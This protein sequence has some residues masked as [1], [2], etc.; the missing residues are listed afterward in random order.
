MPG[1]LS[2]FEA[3]R[4]RFLVTNLGTE[5]IT[6][7]DK[8]A[9]RATATHTLNAP[10]QLEID[11]PSDHPEVN[12][13]AAA[14]DED[15][16]FID[17]GLNLIYWFLRW[18]AGFN[19]VDPPWV[20]EGAGIILNISDRGDSGNP[21]STLTA[22]DPWKLL[23]R[24]PVVNAAGQMPLAGSFLF[25]A[26]SRAS[27]IV[28]TLIQRAESFYD[29]DSRIDI[30][31]F[32]IEN[33]DPLP[34]TMEIQVG[35][36]VGEALDRLVE[37]G[38][39]D[40]FLQPIFDPITRPGKLAELHIFKRKG[41]FKPEAI[42]S[43]DRWPRSVMDIQRQQDGNA[44]ANMVQYWAGVGGPPAVLKQ[45][46]P[47]IAK[48]GTYF[49]QQSYPGNASEAMAGMLAERDIRLRANGQF[50]YTLTPAGE[51]APLPFKEYHLGD[52]VPVWASR[53]LRRVIEDTHLRVQSIP[54]ELSPDQLMR[55]NELTVAI[56]TDPVPAPGP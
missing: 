50:D 44:R 46:T 17:E 13:H 38:T 43:W 23:Y 51:R 56:D 45:S 39:I 54:M 1:G 15:Q 40:I 22:W 34:D 53:R 25:L 24:I 20:C 42:F 33:T 16:P 36:S 12:L 8:I 27:T 9:L 5:A 11:V 52:K 47:S 55:V 6:S 18:G 35:T 2:G 28:K 49:E 7:L 19:T 21:V 4:A 32:N 29:F 10:F 37:T 31:D 30:D 48:Y 41:E 26:E 14:I 3:P